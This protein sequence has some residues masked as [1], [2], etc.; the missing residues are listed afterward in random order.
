MSTQDRQPA[1]DPDRQLARIRR[2]YQ[3]V[4]TET[5]NG[6]MIHLSPDMVLDLAESV[7]QLDRYLSSGGMAPKQWG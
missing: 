1:V 7:A 5:S 2:L 6:S 4:I 3:H